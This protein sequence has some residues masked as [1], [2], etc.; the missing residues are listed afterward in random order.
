MA[1]PIITFKGNCKEAMSF[2]QTVFRTEIK[3]S[4]SYGKYVPEGIETPPEDLRDWIMHAEMEICNTIFRFADEP[5][6][7]SCENMEK[8]TVNVATA[9]LGQEYFDILKVDGNI[10]LPPTE[11]YKSNFHAVVIDKY[12]VYWN[13]VSEEAST[14]NIE[15]FS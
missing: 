15:H 13:I 7:I 11:T 2:Y 5:E 6:L 12:G 14:I 8:L 9:K 1:T 3:S 10:R 4:I